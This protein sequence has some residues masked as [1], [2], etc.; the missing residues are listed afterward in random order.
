M[1]FKRFFLSALACYS[2]LFYQVRVQTEDCVPGSVQ[3]L[4]IAPNATLWWT[5]NPDEP[6]PLT[7]FLVDIVGDAQDEFHLRVSVQHV[8]VSFLNVCE[9]WRFTVSP[10]SDGVMGLERTLTHHI[11]LPPGADLTLKY[12]D[13][14][15]LEGNDVLLEWDLQNRTYG[16][17]SLYYLLTITDEELGITQDVYVQGNILHM[18]VLSPCVPYQLSLRAV[19]KAN[20]TIEGPISTSMI[21]V[22]GR[23]QV[24][25]TLQSIEVQA[26][27][28]NMTWTLEMGTNRCPLKAMYVD[29][30]SQFNIS[31]PLINASPLVPVTVELKSLRPNT[32]YFLKVSV[33]NSVGVSRAAQIGVQTLELSPN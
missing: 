10:F 7:D 20:P 8:D 13:A 19:N 9:I 18:S 17:C 28:V 30:G 22:P 27:S 26:T 14:I 4:D 15:F 6:C 25:P 1:T 16:D 5:V 21:E 12:F 24:T 2:V 32:M 31:V 23:P 33:E 29:A 11:P 3:M